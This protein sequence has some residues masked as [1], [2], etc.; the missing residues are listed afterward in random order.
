[1]EFS[2]LRYA[3]ISLFFLGLIAIE[4]SIP[5]IAGLKSTY[6]FLLAIMAALATRVVRNF[7]QITFSGLSKLTVIIYFCYFTYSFSSVLWSVW[8][9]P[10][11]VHSSLLIAVFIFS[12]GAVK[13]DCEKS[14]D[15]LQS[16]I[17]IA[18]ALSWLALVVSSN[19]ALQQKGIWRLKGIFFHEFELG[20]LCSSLII[21]LC[22][23]WCRSN[24]TKYYK[25]YLHFYS[26]FFITFITLLATQTRT[27][28]AYTFIICV[29]AMIFLAR[30]KKKLVTLLILVTGLFVALA[31]KDSFVEAFSRGESDMTL[32]G[33][34]VIWERAISTADEQPYIGYG[35]GSFTAPQF[36]VDFTGFF[37][38]YRAPHAHNTWIMAYFETG[39]VGVTIL[40]LFLFLQILY[41]IKLANKD[42]GPPYGLFLA[43][44]ATVGG[45]TSLIYAGKVAALAFL[46]LIFMLQRSREIGW[47]VFIKGNRLK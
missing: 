46:P 19:F 47:N 18:I 5:H 12:I 39:I 25:S 22:L 40:S 8:A 14:I 44:L 1:M 42:S 16:I 28:L 13:F 23:R 27:L 6:L 37:G 35:F 3:Y 20:F 41:G 15:K 30:G 24:V 43:V 17:L 21:I 2:R 45:F 29:L 34:T 7:N 36:D 11:F 26:L 32:S 10:T 38:S 33:R 4:L 9:F 31:L